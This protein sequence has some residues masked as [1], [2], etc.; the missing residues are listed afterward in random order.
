MLG[1]LHIIYGKYTL[2]E[3]SAPEGYLV[4]KTLTE[5]NI[6]DDYRNSDTP[7]ATLVNHLK[8]LRFI[9]VDTSGKY[10]PGVEFSLINAS[11]GEVVEV[12]TSNE[13]GEFIFTKF[14]YGFWK[15]RETKVPEG[16]SQMEDID[17][18]VDADWEEPEPFTCLN[19]PNHYEF[20]KTDNEG[21]PMAGVK[22]TLED[23]AGNILRNLVSGAD[24]I[25]HVTDLA[26]GTYIIREIE[27]LEGYSISGE[28]IEV[29]IDEH[30][31]VPEEMYV[32]VNYP[33]IQTGVDFEITPIMWVGGF[34][35]LGGVLLLIAYILGHRKSH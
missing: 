23:S 3:L 21:K 22:F 5:V 34:A 27:T 6:N 16:Y 17:F 11:T 29:V 30:Y 28:T 20:V 26:P 12:V 9:K 7:A 25:V 1:S 19:I 4:S 24:G 15:I 14:D 10:L 33:N 31:T 13:K 35:L 18:N 32:L 8:R 2:K